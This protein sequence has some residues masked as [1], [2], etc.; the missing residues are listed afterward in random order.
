[1]VSCSQ[2]ATNGTGLIEDARLSTARRGARARHLVGLV[3]HG[4]GVEHRAELRLL[5]QAICNG[6]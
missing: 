1:M 4:G 6:R 5:D 3:G 2:S